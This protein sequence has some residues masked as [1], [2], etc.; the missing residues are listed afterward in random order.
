ML[1]CAV[2]RASATRWR[3]AS[4]WRLAGVAVVRPCWGHLALK[5]SSL[6]ERSAQSVLAHDRIVPGFEQP[7]VLARVSPRVNAH[8]ILSDTDHF[9]CFRTERQAAA[10]KL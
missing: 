5:R 7:G 1:P 4:S 6:P 8:E 3:Q 9:D 10:Q 2:H